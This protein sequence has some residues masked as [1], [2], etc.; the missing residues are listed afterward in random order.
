MPIKDY[1]VMVKKIR[2]LI[3]FCLVLFGISAGFFL[4]YRHSGNL[5]SVTQVQK[6]KPTIVFN[7]KKYET[8]NG[9]R[10]IKLHEEKPAKYQLAES[11]LK[12]ISRSPSQEANATPTL[13]P[14]Q[15]LAGTRWK[16]WSQTRV[17]SKSSDGAPLGQVSN[18]KIVSDP[19]SSANLNQFDPK[20]PIA[21]FNE[22]LKKP[23]IITGTIKLETFDRSPLEQELKVLKAHIT[24]SFENINTYLV[25]GSNQV[26]DLEELFVNLKQLPFVTNVE[27]EILSKSYEK[28]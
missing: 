5:A 28:D 13:L 25:T 10:Q 22:R 3:L 14:S 21:V 4:V 24:D 7:Y 15:I 23:G 11:H 6:K 18:L 1:Y 9:K 12:Q 8:R 20:N 17:S 27:I 19:D 2:S 16:I 26:F